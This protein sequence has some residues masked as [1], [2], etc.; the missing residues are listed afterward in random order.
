MSHITIPRAALEA[1]PYDKGQVRMRQAG[2]ARPEGDTNCSVQFRFGPKGV[3][4][5][6]GWSAEGVEGN[7]EGGRTV[8]LFGYLFGLASCISAHA[9]EIPLEFALSHGDTI[10]VPDVGVFRVV[11]NPQ[12][13]QADFPQLEV[14]RNFVAEGTETDEILER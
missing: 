8:D 7:R 2:L 11:P 5:Q 3:K 14:I 13:W 6:V 1:D 4:K 9:Q 12:R 10:E